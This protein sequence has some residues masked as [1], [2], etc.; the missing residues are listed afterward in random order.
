MPLPPTDRDLRYASQVAYPPFGLAGQARLRSGRVLVVGVGG[1][2]CTTVDLLARAGVGLLRLVDDDS[3]SLANLHRQVLFDESDAEKKLPKVQAAAN[4][5]AA[6]NG[7][8]RVE[9]RGVRL[10]AANAGDLADGMDVIV[11]GT[12]NF[13]TRFILNDLAVERGLPWVFAGVVGGEAQL[14]TVIPGRTPCL[15]CVF[16][17]PPPPCMDPTCTAA[18]VLGPAVAAVAS[19]QAMEV[20]KLL[21][22]ADAALSRCLTKMDLWTGQVQRLEMDSGQPAADCP[23]CKRRDFEFLY[24]HD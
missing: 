15:R 1:L 24:P 9:P 8:V 13:E 17:Q 5:I 16:D 7:E 3:V 14:M 21:I 18:G 23:C 22:G 12:D 11:D 6:V 2:G 20:L 10:G 19:L 4:R